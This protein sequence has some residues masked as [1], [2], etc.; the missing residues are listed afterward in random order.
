MS[1][2]ASSGWPVLAAT[3]RNIDG[4]KY[5]PGVPSSPDG[6]GASVTPVRDEREVT[7]GRGVPVEVGDGLA[8]AERGV[9]DGAVELGGLLGRGDGALAAEPVGEGPPAGQVVGGEAESAVLGV[10]GL[11]LAAQPDLEGV[12]ALAGVGGA[13]PAG[14]ASSARARRRPSR[15][16]SSPSSGSGHPGRLPG[17]DV[18][19]DGLGAAALRD[20]VLGAVHARRWPAARGRS[21]RCAARSLLCRGRAGRRRRRTGRSGGSRAASHRVRRRPWPGWRASA[22]RRRIPRTT[23]APVTSG[24]CF[25]NRATACSVRAARSGLPHHV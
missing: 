15:P 2:A 13:G 22:C 24:C 1:W 6:I 18:V 20:R 17:L 7:A 4:L 9:L 5:W 25:S 12:L 3:P 16:R 14:L 23:S 11:A 21:R 10:E 8:A 19:D